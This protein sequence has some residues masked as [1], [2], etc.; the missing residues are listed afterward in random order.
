[1]NRK[2]NT[3]SLQQRTCLALLLVLLE[4]F[5]PINAEDFTVNGV[6]Y[7]TINEKS[8]M[9]IKTAGYSGDLIIPS[10]VERKGKTYSV[11]KINN[12]AFSSCSL[13][14]SV[15]LPNSITEIPLEAF[16]YCSGLTSVS[17]PNSVVNIYAN[18]FM[19]CKGLTSVLVPNSVIFIGDGAFSGCDKLTSVTIGDNVQSIGGGAFRECTELLEISIPNRVRSLGAGAF[20]GCYN[21]SSV[22]IGDNVISIGDRSFEGC[23]ALT[24][25]TIP[26]SVTSI[27]SKAFYNCSNLTS[28]TIPNSVTS[29]GGGTF[30]GCS[31]LSSLT[32]EDGTQILNF[33]TITSY[34]LLGCSLKQLYIGRNFSYPSHYSP[35]N[36]NSYLTTLTLSDK[37][38]LIGEEAFSGCSN[39]TSVTLGDNVQS[40]GLSAFQG[41]SSLTSLDIPNSVTNIDEKAFM[42]CSGLTSLTIPYSATSISKGAFRECNNL[43]SLTILCPQVD[44]WFRGFKSIKEIVLGD[45]VES[46]GSE[47]FRD[48]VGLS[49]VTLGKSV[50]SIGKNAFSGCKNFMINSFASYPPQMENDINVT[51]LEVPVGS[52]GRYATAEHWNVIDTIYSVKDNTRLYPVLLF[53][54]GD[55]VV[56]L[57]TDSQTGVENEEGGKNE[58]ML[59]NNSVQNALIM[60]NGADITDMIKQEGKYVFQTSVRHK[61][62][63][64]ES[65]VYPTLVI[66]IEESGTLINNI[67]I[68]DINNIQSLKVIGD[69]NGTDVR[70]IRKM[71]N[72]KLLNLEDANIVKGGMAY[73]EDNW[74]SWFT[75][76]NTISSHFFGGLDSLLCIN[77]PQTILV[78]NGGPFNG[79]KNLRSITIPNSITIINQYL[80]SDRVS[81]TSVSIPTSVTSI[82]NDAFSDCSSLKKITIPESVTSIGEKAFWG[83][84]SLYSVTSMCTTPPKIES[85]TFTQDTYDTATLNVPVGCK[86]NYWLSPYWENFKNIKEVDVTSV[87]NILN[88]SAN[89]NGIVYNLQGVRVSSNSGEMN[90]LSKGIYIFNGKKIIVK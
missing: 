24:T 27:G 44:S 37:V 59:L 29:I 15:T 63:T 72:L 69:I 35:F 58:I 70:T 85:N 41:C 90:Q 8:V 7:R 46:I 34:P 88:D 56:S 81:L 51:I 52:G 21:L 73:Y 54:Y 4:T 25:I 13:I 40:I 36:S 32:I 45:N 75:S 9:V 17:I 79:C 22:S 3:N 80:F 31:K 18:A 33:E 5:L 89:N 47:A 55:N 16:M 2:F 84:T 48:C 1:M 53:A 30:Q 74:N 76:D 14:T 78:L 38:T 49:S 62:N 82:G 77:L 65:Y 23:R 6:N 60:Q 86:A 12:C 61:D 39:L 57:N 71:T 11:I 50:N 43:T 87:K 83:C 42:D 67:E 28:F 68:E 26:N 19:G 64:I 10:T 66:Q 20:S